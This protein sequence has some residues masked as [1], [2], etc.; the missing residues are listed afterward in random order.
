MS[1]I[2]NRLK[3]FIKYKG[4]SVLGF[5]K[6]IYASNGYV[7][8][9]N[10]ITKAKERLLTDKF[11]DLSIKWLLTGEGEMINSNVTESSTNEKRKTK[12][13]TSSE[14]TDTLDSYNKELIKNLRETIEEQRYLIQTQKEIIELLKERLNNH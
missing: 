12:A 7:N 13:P 6:A 14:T 9:C 5:E 8:S 11:P 3:E 1:E 4:Y 2:S 10:T